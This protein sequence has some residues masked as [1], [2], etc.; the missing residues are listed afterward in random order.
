[1]VLFYTRTA[2]LQRERDF[3]KEHFDEHE[4]DTYREDHE[5]AAVD[6]HAGRRCLS[7]KSEL[8]THL[9]FWRR[10][11]TKTGAIDS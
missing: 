8:V 4:Q 1:M 7:L 10:T 6:R 9:Y 2:S 5:M 3:V 11:R